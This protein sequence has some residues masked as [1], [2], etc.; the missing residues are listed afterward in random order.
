MWSL[1]V[2]GGRAQDARSER[3]RIRGLTSFG[4]DPRGELYAP[5]HAGVIY[6]LVD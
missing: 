3:F 6:R 2:R 5:S 4:E 1:V